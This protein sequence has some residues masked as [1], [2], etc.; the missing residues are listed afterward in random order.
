MSKRK[1]KKTIIMLCSPLSLVSISVVSV[2]SYEKNSWDRYNFM[3]TSRTNAQYKRN[4]RYNLL[5]EIEWILSGVWIFFVRQIQRYGNQ[6]V[7]VAYWARVRPKRINELLICGSLIYTQRVP[8][9]P[10]D[11]CVGD[12]LIAFPP[13]LYL[14]SYYWDH[15]AMPISQ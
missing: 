2:V 7:I 14:T 13:D 15:D 6:A 9:S 1:E 12:N 11:R 5:Y 10:M 4:D 3:E 8:G